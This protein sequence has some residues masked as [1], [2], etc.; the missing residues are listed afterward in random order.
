[1]RPTLSG[2][3]D[4]LLFRRG[5]L[6]PIRVWTLTLISLVMRRRKS[7]FPPT[8]PEGQTPQLRFAPLLRLLLPLLRRMPELFCIIFLFFVGLQTLGTCDVVLN[9]YSIFYLIA[10]IFFCIFSF[11]YCFPDA[12]LSSTD[13]GR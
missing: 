2:L 8:V 4:G 3:L 1:M 5:L 12:A 6:M 10:S 11:Y 7:P 9:E 13:V